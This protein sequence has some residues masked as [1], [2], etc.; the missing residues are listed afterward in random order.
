MPDGYNS[1]TP[2][3]VVND[4]P[5]SIEYCKDAFGA[6]ESFMGTPHSDGKRL[7]QTGS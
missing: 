3:M 4:G 6:Q 7:L 1:L 2:Y 5:K